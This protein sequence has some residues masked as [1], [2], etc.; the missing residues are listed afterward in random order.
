MIWCILVL[1]GL[2]VLPIFCIHCFKGCSYDYAIWFLKEWIMDEYHHRSNRFFVNSSYRDV[3]LGDISKI[4][5][6]DVRNRWLGVL[7]TETLETEKDCPEDDVACYKLVIPWDESNEKLYRDIICRTFTEFLK[8]M[9]ATLQ[10]VSIDFID[11]EQ[12]EY[13]ICRVRYARTVDELEALTKFIDDKN[14][15]VVG[16]TSEYRDL[17][18]D[19]KLERYRRKKDDD[20]KDRSKID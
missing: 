11:W 6:E 1:L 2:P 5:R 4:L 15:D 9:N 20:D 16:D 7:E 12:T 10:T 13:R 3:L 8:N 14:R 17:E 19:A 18:L